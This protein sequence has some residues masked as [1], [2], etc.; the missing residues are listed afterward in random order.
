MKT[1][2]ESDPEGYLY[3]FGRML[4]SEGHKVSHNEGRI[5]VEMEGSEFEIRKD[6]SSFDVTGDSGKFLKHMK[7]VF[8]A[9]DEDEAS[10]KLRSLGFEIDE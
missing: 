7:S 6:E 2:I 5:E 10:E 3:I 8:R 9:E 4:K 1:E